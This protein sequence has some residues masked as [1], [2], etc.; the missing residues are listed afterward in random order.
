TE[1]YA[2]GL[3]ARSWSVRGTDVRI[4]YE[5]RYPGWAPGCDGQTEQED[6]YHLAPVAGVTRVGRQE[7]DAWHR[8][9]HAVV[10][11]LMAAMAA[12]DETTPTA[13]VPHRRPRTRPP[14][15]LA[16]HTGVCAGTRPR[17]CPPGR[18]AT[19]ARVGRAARSRWRRPP[20]AS[21]GR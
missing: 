13:L 11:R 4:R 20:T 6:V 7:H 17:L 19:G 14:L 2:E 12:R 16:P 10:G 18:P 21:R 1:I 8:D 3:L 5:V 9:L 15:H